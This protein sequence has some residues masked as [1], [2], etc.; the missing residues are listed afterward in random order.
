MCELALA[1]INSDR[2]EAAYRRTDLF[3]RR[4]ELMQQ[5]DD[6]VAL[7]ATTPPPSRTAFTNR[8]YFRR[9]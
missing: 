4:R 1:H 8:S 2:V 6:Y 5:W 3:E 9:M 7:D